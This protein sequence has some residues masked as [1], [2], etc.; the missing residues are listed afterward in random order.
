MTSMSLHRHI[1]AAAALALLAPVGAAYAQQD[2]KPL[3]AEVEAIKQQVSRLQP[4][5]SG[6][7]TPST[8]QTPQPPPRPPQQQRESLRPEFAPFSS[9]R[10]L[11]AQAPS[12]D[13]SASEAD[14]E[15]S[16]AAPRRPRHRRD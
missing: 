12:A 4:D 15:R 10:A 13:E 1:V 8:P 16:R 2:L 5:L 9:T 3:Q 14:A 11:P 7:Q 6:A